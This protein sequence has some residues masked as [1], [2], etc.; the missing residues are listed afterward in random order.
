MNIH[1][2]KKNAGR[3]GFTLMEVIVGVAVFA[4]VAMAAYQAFVSLFA[5]TSADQYKILAL[6]LA[7]EEFEIA[8][9][10]PYNSIGIV[11]GIPSGKIPYQQTLL[12]GGVNFLV[13]ATVRNIDL[14]YDGIAD[15]TPDDQSPADNKL[16]EFTITCPNCA[17]F[18]PI[19]LS[20]NIAPK[21]LETAS[22]NGALSIK[23]FDAN[24]VALQGADVTV[25]NSKVTPNITVHD[26]TDVN[27]ILQIVDAAT[28]T[29]AYNISVTKSGYSTDR[30]YPPGGSGNP[31]PTKPDSTVLL[32]QVT[33]V[34]FSIDKTST[35]SFSSL[36]S[37]CG[38]VPNIDFTLKGSKVIGAGVLKY[39]QSKVTDSAGALSLTGME[40][41]S[42]SIA[43]T[44]AAYDL[45]GLSPLNSIA[46]NPNAT[47]SVLLIVAPKNPKSILVTV[48][49][50]STQLPLSG[51]LVTLSKAGY[52]ATTT[53][54]QGYLTQTDWS[55]G[56]AQASYTDGTKY[57]ADDG[58]VEIASPA[59]DM[60]LKKAFGSY[61]SNGILESS[62]FDTG[63]AS[64]FHNLFWT[65][66]DQP[67]G[68][69]T[70]TPPARFQIATNAV[71]TATTTWN[72][73]GPDGTAATYYTSS[74]GT[75]SVDHD[76]D[77]YLR[78]RAYLHTANGSST[79]TV[80]DVSFTY[81]SSCTPPG[82]VTF[83]GLS[84]GTYSLSVS[85]SGYTTYVGTA[86]ASTSWMEQSVLLGP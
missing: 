81:T 21:N 71:V 46:L 20:S 30:T 8:R 18:T 42:Y 40:W 1:A 22:T 75:V 86:N 64:N 84:T 85:K 14:P 43:L 19:T 65:P 32:Q 78:Y 53:T 72:Y 36:T 76:G 3:A 68:A 51:A 48:K 50:S 33:P 66:T 56:G 38:A 7:N 54:G 23:V 61:V 13:T 60:K 69:G 41:D 9:N 77:Q 5:I 74:G 44:D 79:P 6:N 12:R 80:S 35:L 47:Q 10:M 28:G 24:G 16:V 37:T 2:S 59:G 17:N 39:S 4:I 63:S 11:N 26:I 15:G 52:L 29:N 45:I 83:S 57:F 67:A 49:D 58:N 70:T 31:S 27:G 34:S 82:Q 25:V 62:T 73:E 55:G